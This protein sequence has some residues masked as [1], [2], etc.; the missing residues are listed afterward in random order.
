MPEILQNLYRSYFNKQFD[1]K[2]DIFSHELIILNK[3]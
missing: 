2:G 1:L 3:G